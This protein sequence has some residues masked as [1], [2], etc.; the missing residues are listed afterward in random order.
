MP[1]SPIVNANGG[2]LDLTGN[3]GFYHQKDRYFALGLS[4]REHF[5]AMALQGILSNSAIMS[6]IDENTDDP[7]GMCEIVSNMSKSFADELLKE[8]DA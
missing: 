3:N 7:S 4:K 6:D 8:L 5:A 1:I 2:V